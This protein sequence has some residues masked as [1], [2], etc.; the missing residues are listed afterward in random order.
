MLKK[1]LFA[2]AL[3]DAPT[4]A[5]AHHGWSSYDATRVINHEAALTDLS[6]T[7]PH[8]TAKVRFRDATWDVE[9]APVARMEARGLTPEML[10]PGEVVTLVG[11]PRKDG[12]RE[13]RIE[14][15]TAGDR[16]IELR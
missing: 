4:V 3:V 9:L 1:L 2:A 14:R 5:I 8:G 6:W 16:T 13:M 11:Y 10:G 7:N 12:T 15:V